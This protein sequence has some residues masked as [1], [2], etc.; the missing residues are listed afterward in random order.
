MD[1]WI[2]TYRGGFM[3][4]AGPTCEEIKV[5]KTFLWG[6]ERWHI[7]SVYVCDEGIVIDFCVERPPQLFKEYVNK[8]DLLHSRRDDFTREQL[9]QIENENPDNIGFD[10]E[11]RVNGEELCYRQDFGIYYVPQDCMPNYFG[12]DKAAKSAI[13]H[14]NLD[15]SMGWVIRRL[16]L[17]WEGSD[18]AIETLTIKMKRRTVELPGIHFPTPENGGSVVFNHPVTGTEHKLTVQECVC[19]KLEGHCDDEDI[20]YPIFYTD[21]LYTLDPDLP[22]NSFRIQDYNDGDD[23]RTK[24]AGREKSQPAAM[25]YAAVVMLTPD[26]D[27]PEI[28]NAD[29]STARIHTSFSHFYFEPKDNIE[30]YMIFNHKIM[31]DIDIRVI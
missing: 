15:P 3:T 10:T 9:M 28:V 19:R 1:K 31:D 24:K 26:N 2:V 18:S 22:E 25:G 30:W 4:N 12:N 7:P 21:L 6:D 5:E 29:G 8:W 16:V 11:I 13:E 14:Y 27:E 23:P 20:E 17:G